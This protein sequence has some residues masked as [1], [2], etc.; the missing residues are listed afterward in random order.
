MHVHELNPYKTLIALSLFVVVLIIG[1][2]TMH[3]PFVTFDKDMSQ[4]LADLNQKEALFYPWQLESFIGKQDQNM[5]L[6]DLRDRFI[7]G[8]G[9]ISGSENI[10]ANDLTL[11][12]SIERLKALKEKNT[13]VV[14]YGNSQ[15]EANG[16]WML[17]RQVGFDNV[18]ILAGG[19][20][21]YVQHKD[22]LAACKTD[23]TLTNEKP[24]YNFAEIASQVENISS[25]SQPVEKK[26][27]NVV[28]KAKP[29]AAA[30]G[31]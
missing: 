6:F 27:V 3:K 20:Q 25:V 8:Q 4:S 10:S 28:R 12:E 24:K 15:L 19:Y 13:T 31:C 18:K 11:G 5:V 1:F 29:A 17:F 26:V 2:F 9:N 16:P 21:Y 30:G 14:L 7:Y 23:S 22:D